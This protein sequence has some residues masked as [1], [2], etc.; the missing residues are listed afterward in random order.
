MEVGVGGA[1]WGAAV[2][3]V[4]RGGGVETEHS[5]GEGGAGCKGGD[6]FKAGSGGELKELFR[7]FG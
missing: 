2:P 1:A 7:P 3:F 4:G 6:G 5:G